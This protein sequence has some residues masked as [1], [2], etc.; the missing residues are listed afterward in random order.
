MYFLT[1]NKKSLIVKVLRERPC[2]CLKKQ[3]ILSKNAF[4]YLINLS[5][6]SFKSVTFLQQINYFVS[7]KKK[8]R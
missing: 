7:T 6:L 5:S 3:K 1:L 8:K 2:Y 4:F